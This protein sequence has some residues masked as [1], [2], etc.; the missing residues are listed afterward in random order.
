MFVPTDDAGA[1]APTEN[2]EQERAN[3]EL[4]ARADLAHSR[5]YTNSEL[6]P[7]E[8]A[9]LERHPEAFTE[10]VLEIGC[11]PGRLT[12]HLARRS[13]S[14]LAIDVSPAMVEACRRRHPD[15]TVEL[16]D[17]RDVA[18]LGSGAFDTV[19]APYNVLDVLGDAGRRE[20]LEAIHLVLAPDG[21]FV[22]SSH[23]L[24]APPSPKIFGPMRTRDA[25]RSLPSLP[26]MLRNRRRL[27]RLERRADDYAILN[28]I[29]HDYGALHYYT[30]RD[31]QERQL[32]EHGFSLIECV[33]DR[34][35]QVPAGEKAAHASE[36]HY[37]A[38]KTR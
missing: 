21:F 30:T 23:N 20:T 10:R 9:I 8:Q 12:G 6:R 32:T 15:V 18:S 33:D 14:V 16:K 13:D 22:L 24:A 5:S 25:V 36:L 35:E 38:R 3:S 34:G 28:D 11:G 7:A 27:R 29:S 26:R 1:G 17:L 4:W 31:A 37:V 19:V 2:L